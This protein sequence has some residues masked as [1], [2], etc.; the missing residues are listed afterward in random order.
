MYANK[1]LKFTAD[2]ISYQWHKVHLCPSSTLGLLCLVWGLPF[3]ITVAVS[4]HSQYSG[5]LMACWA[6]GV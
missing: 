6:R 1:I 2:E 5:T 3:A 4:A